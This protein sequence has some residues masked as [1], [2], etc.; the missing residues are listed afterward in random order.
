[1]RFVGALPRS[2]GTARLT[3]ISSDAVFAGPYMFHEETSPGI[4]HAPAR[5]RSA[6]WSKRSPRLAHSWYEPTPSAGVR[7]RNTPILHQRP[8]EQL[9]SGGSV[10]ADGRRHATPILATDLA[11]LLHRAYELRMPRAVPPLRRRTNEPLGI[12]LRTGLGTGSR[13]PARAVGGQMVLD[14]RSGRRN[15]AKQQKDA[16]HAGTSDPDAA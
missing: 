15:V 16:A 8:Y 1:M 14:R 6:R 5:R 11:E 7:W 10:E 3:V 13:L 2:A 4:S 12:R 9:S